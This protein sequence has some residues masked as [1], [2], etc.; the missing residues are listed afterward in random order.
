MELYHCSKIVLYKYVYEKE[1]VKICLNFMNTLRITLQE[2][3][4]NEIT[5]VRY[6]TS[7]NFEY[8]EREID[9][10]LAKVA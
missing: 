5:W 3:W 10:A 2:C 4:T 6:K 8:I 7:L 9:N 1:L